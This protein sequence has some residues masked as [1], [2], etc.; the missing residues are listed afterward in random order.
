MAFLFD[1]AE[2]AY[3]LDGARLPS[4][5]QILHEAGIGTDYSMVPPQILE[6]KRQVGVAV[7]AACR[8]VDE[9][10]LD[11][12]T[13]ADEIAPYV[14]S[15]Q[16][17]LADTGFRAIGTELPLYDEVRGYAGTP[18]V[19]GDLNGRFALLDRKTLWTLDMPTAALQAA[20]Y[21]PLIEALEPSWR[22][23]DRYAL[24]LQRT[25]RYRLVPAAIPA[26]DATFLAA[27]AEVRGDGTDD[28]AAI[29]R[30]WKETY[31]P[32]DSHS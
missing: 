15:Y 8:L 31:G 23:A 18:D 3:Y 5:T 14:G 12:S 22:G 29:L 9:G 13:V 2:H 6:H 4:V 19:W 25:G 27:L 1:P 10:E 26:A 30:Q 7:H 32:R 11:E 24:H 17:F 21:A 16:Q 28:T 20:G